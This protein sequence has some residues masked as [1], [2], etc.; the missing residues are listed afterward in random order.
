MLFEMYAVYKLC[1]IGSAVNNTPS[2][3]RLAGKIVTHKQYKWKLGTINH[4][5]YTEEGVFL[6][7]EG[8]DSLVWESLADVVFL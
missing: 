4:V 1:Q 8:K 5:H 2:R 3:H 7:F 6:S